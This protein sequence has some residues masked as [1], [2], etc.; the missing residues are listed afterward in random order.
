MDE[1]S[2]AVAS[3]LVG[4]RREQV[5]ALAVLDAALTGA[6]GLLLITGEAGVG[7]TRFIEELAGAVKNRVLWG[8]CWSDP[9]PLRSGRGP[10]CCA[11]A[12]P[13]LV[14]NASVRILPRRTRV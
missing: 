6:G 13:Q 11:I 4:R 9:A 10:R 7:K 8:A 1:Q 5:E 12:R 14:V 3:G 2:S